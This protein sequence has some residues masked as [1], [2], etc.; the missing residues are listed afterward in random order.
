M[1]AC[2]LYCKSCARLFMQQLEANGSKHNRAKSV[3]MHYLV[4]CSQTKE[5]EQ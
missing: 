4:C 3:P 5:I 1:V 2:H